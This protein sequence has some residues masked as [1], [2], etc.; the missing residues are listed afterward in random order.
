MSSGTILT[1]QGLTRAYKVGGQALPVLKGVDLAVRRGEVLAI[2]GRSGVGKSTL[3]HCLGILDAPDGGSLRYGDEDLARASAGRRATVRN[4]EFGFV[5]Q[6]YHL[7]PEFTAFENVLMPALVGTRPWRWW[8]ARGAARARAR[9]LLTRV[10]L[11]DRAHHRPSQLSGGE[12]QRVA[13]ARALMNDPK[14]LFCDEP[15]GNLDATT[16]AEVMAL[17]AGLNAERGQTCVLVTHDDAI[18]RQ[19]HRVARMV[20]GKVAEITA[21]GARG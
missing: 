13:I 14:I 12:Q 8:R 5:F 7:L 4:R 10:G 1:A 21:N 20:D 11:A 3:L 19:A 16:A 17:L 9:D 2:V 6:F 18:A 15:T